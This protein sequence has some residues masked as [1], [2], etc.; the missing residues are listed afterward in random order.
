MAK[1]K[2]VEIKAKGIVVLLLDDNEKAWLPGQELSTKFTFSKKLPEQNLCSQGDELDVVV[3]GEEFG[4]KKKLVSHIRFGK[5]PWDKVKTWNCGDVKEIV[6]YSVTASRAYGW[7]EPG[8]KGFIELSDI[9]KISGFPR[10]WKNFTTISAGDIISGFV[11]EDEIDVKNRLV[12]LFYSEYVESLKNIPE[13]LPILKKNS[14]DTV[15]NYEPK[16]PNHKELVIKFPPGIQH[17]LVVDDD[18]VFLNEIVS[19]LKSCG[20]KATKAISKSEAMK[21]ITDSECPDFDV[22]IL[23]V[24]L[25]EGY[26]YSGFQVAKAIVRL[27]SRCNIIMTTG[28]SLESE[29]VRK[30]AGNLLISGFLYKPFGV[31]EL[32]NI[33]SNVM[34]GKIKKLEDF[35]NSPG[36]EIEPEIPKKKEIM[37]PISIACDLKEK[38]QAEIVVLFSIHPLSYEVQIEAYCGVLEDKAEEYLSKMRY[39]PVKDVA[40]NEEILFEG[41][42]QKTPKYSKHRWLVKALEYESCIGFPVNIDHELSYCLFAFHGNENH[43]DDFDKYKVKTAAERIAQL[44]ENKKLEETIRSENPFYLAGKTY[45]SMAHDL[46]DALNREFGLIPI[47][48]IIENK[49]NIENEGILEI[50][51]HLENLRGELERAKGIVDTFR[52]MSRSQHEEKTEVD[53]F[54]TVNQVAKIIKVEA[55]ALNTKITVQT[56]DK[57]IAGKIRIVKPA[58]EQV[59]YNLFLNAAQQIKR[60]DFVREKGYIIVEFANVKSGDKDWLRILIHDSGPGIHTRDFK[61]IFQKGYTTKEDGCG[62]GLDICQNI[63]NEAG[64]EIRV[65]KS[66]LFCGT[67][68][69]ILLPFNYKEA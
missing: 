41:K 57:E 31:E 53:V 54:D 59:L 58:F 40:I 68:F 23:D 35:F 44:M 21:S 12:K 29:E 7:I 60:F 18:E 33:I 65:L 61:K 62:M 52:R 9:A 1:A 47:F 37:S 4:G 3:Y 5:D 49:T 46:M 45:G 64:G 30:N 28:D 32:S 24:N 15:D 48:K 42:I 19:Y 51:K 13:F 38:T 63:I 67:T 50:K 39:S 14:S 66:I 34:S 8:I 25:M 17:I 10:S 69:E 56:M 55:E 20:I 11:K 27:Q 43:F 2:I 22:A 26:G 6:V 36:E 16:T